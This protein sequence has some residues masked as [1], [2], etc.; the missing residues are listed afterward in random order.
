MVQPR[1]SDAYTFT[2][3]TDEGV[4]LWLNGQLLIDNWLAHGP[5]DDLATVQLVAGQNY[6]LRLDYYEDTGSA[7]AKLF[8]SSA[9]V[10]KEIIPQS[11]LFP[12]QWPLILVQPVSQ[13]VGFGANLVLSVVATN[14]P[15]RY[16]WYLN[17]ALLARATNS[18][19]AITNAQGTN[20]GFYEVVVSSAVG[21]VTSSPAVLAVA[22]LPLT[23]LTQPV[24]VTVG[25]VTNIVTTN[26]ATFRVNASGMAPPT[27]QWTFWATNLPGATNATLTVSNV[28]LEVA[29][30]Y[31]ARATDGFTTLTTTN[32]M[33]RLLVK[34]TIVV[35]IQPQSVVYGG[36]ATFS[37]W[38]EPQHPAVPI[39]FRWLRGGIYFL[40]NDQPT[41]IVSQVTTSSTYQV[42]AANSAG[43][44]FKP[45]VLLTVLAD[46]DRDGLPDNLEMAMGYP[47]NNATDGALDYD[48]DGMSNAAEVAAGTDPMDPS[49]VLKLVFPPDPVAE[50]AAAF[51]FPAV[52]N[53]TYTAE[54]QD[55]IEGAGWSNL[56][57]FDSLPTNRFLWVTN[58]PP[59]GVPHRFYRVETP[60]KP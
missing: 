35:P 55:G 23:L 37:V 25:P 60:R 19:Y 44:A 8:W 22:K 3:S 49:S 26:S 15:T 13:T 39:S 53:K 32:A 50:G 24:D 57:S 42:V 28:S 33:L 47:T 46:T 20:A 41:L 48:G 38:V 56:V 11:Q 1:Y 21:S 58:L 30:P 10:P 18:V 2:T 5:S 17:D 40:T 52:S 4:R 34:P 12:Y 43:S 51:Y 16:Q 45:P 29:G 54:Y 59:T 14:S 31:A 7:V 6:N 36:T 27:Y 9:H